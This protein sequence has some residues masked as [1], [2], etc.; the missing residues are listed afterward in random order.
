MEAITEASSIG[1][2]IDQSNDGLWVWYKNWVALV[3]SSYMVSYRITV[4]T[5]KHI[6]TG[7]SAPFLFV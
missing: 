3:Y 2:S 6:M 4:G 5:L 7:F 1:C